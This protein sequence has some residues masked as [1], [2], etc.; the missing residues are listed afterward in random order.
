MKP[1]QTELQHLFLR[2][3]FGLKPTQ[4]QEFEGKSVDKILD[5]IFKQAEN[6]TNFDFIKNDE[7]D[8]I[9]PKFLP[10]N[11]K[12]MFRKERKEENKMLNIKW[13]NKMEDNNNQLR[14]KM[15]Y[16][17]HTHFACKT[18][19]PVFN[20]LQNNTL[21]KHA[22]GS[23]R[24]LLMAIAKDPAMLQ[25]LNNQQNKKE[26][27]NENFAREVM[28]LFTLGQKNYTEN[29][30]KN[31]ARAFTGWGIDKSEAKFRFRE[32]QHDF[33][34][35][36][37]MG[38]KGNFD[39]VDILKIILQKPETAFFITKKI[40]RFFVNDVVDEIIV[41]KLADNFYKSDYDIS[42]LMREIFSAQWFYDQK[43]IATK[44]KSPIELLIG[45]KRTFEIDFVD[46]NAHLFVQK[47]LGQMLLNPPNVAGWA[48]G[49]AFIDSSSL[50][51][52]LQLTQVLFNQSVVEIDNKDDGDDNAQKYNKK[53]GQPLQ[54]TLNLKGFEV[55]LERNSAK[56]SNE[57]SNEK[58]AKNIKNYLIQGE[59]S[60]NKIAFEA[61]ITENLSANKEDFIK[62]I[63]LY[64]TALPEYQMQ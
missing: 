48:G 62:K 22:L 24:E 10:R 18:V 49:R 8:Q 61:H 41:K 23:F 30:I 57:K 21:R 50:L 43:N 1:T 55:F 4:L 36:T 42:K 58:L 34:E 12:R 3:G 56:K 29:D 46:E 14:E 20:Q 39:G 27:P 31:A 13:L 26:S 9:N 19:N 11:E 32:K 33:D 59:N 2:A 40:Y 52:R 17:W 54:A 51:F 47:V 25:F 63:M 35:K 53:S 60:L 6:Y 7:D 44:I 38:Q 28:E 37:F 64:L 16:F 5:I 15:T 45:L